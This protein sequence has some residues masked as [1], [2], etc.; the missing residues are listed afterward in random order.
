[1]QVFEL[2]LHL[3]MPGGLCVEADVSKRG[4]HIRSGTGL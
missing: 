2:F 4:F 3:T 1:M